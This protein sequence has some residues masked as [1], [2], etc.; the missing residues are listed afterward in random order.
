MVTLYHW[1][2]RRDFSLAIKT[3]KE[4]NFICYIQLLYYY[5]EE[6]HFSIF[7]INTAYLLCCLP[8]V[9]NFNLPLTLKYLKNIDIFNSSSTTAF[10]LPRFLEFLLVSYHDCP[11]LFD[12]KYSSCAT[13]LQTRY[14][15]AFFMNS[16]NCNIQSQS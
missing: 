15:H 5:K 14:F 13:Y 6:L 3:S 8:I 12:P 4:L 1:N 11:I 7:R 10:V 16:I 2:K 9:Y